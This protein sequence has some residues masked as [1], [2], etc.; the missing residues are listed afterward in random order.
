MAYEVFKANANLLLK[1]NHKGNEESA[2]YTFTR[3]KESDDFAGSETLVDNSSQEA[4]RNTKQLMEALRPF[5]EG[6]IDTDENNNE[7]SD[8]NIKYNGYVFKNS[9]L[10][11]EITDH[12]EI[13]VNL[14]DRN[15]N[16]KCGQKLYISKSDENINVNLI[17]IL[18]KRIERGVESFFKSIRLA[19]GNETALESGVN[20]IQIFLAGNSSKSPILK[21]LFNKNIEEENKR[22]S[23]ESRTDGEHFKLFPPLGTSEAFEIQKERGI[24]VNENDVTAPTGK[25]GVAYGLI[26][27]REGGVIKVISEVKP[28]E[29]TKFRYNLG[30]QHR[31][32]F[33]LIMDRS[34]D[35]GVWV[36]FIDAGVETFE[37]YY[38]SAPSFGKLSIDAPSVHKIP[39]ILPY[40]DAES[41]V[42]IR[43]V[44]PEEI[45]Y[46]I[47]EKNTKP[48]EGADTIRVHLS[49]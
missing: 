29:E 39:C 27:G 16:E 1:N 46:T 24:E 20:E 25:T 18:E 33:K 38:T 48:D 3:P 49:E 41:D 15:G 45:E 9:P 17:E 13:T 6:I 32:M 26:A 40:T 47:A 37:I 30:R 12:G 28:D 43:A 2:G 19:F 21:K 36:R 23:A 31:K 44:S 5:W 34:I 14:F 4:R 8:E 35:Y 22:I 42:Y 10:L 7:N 11:K